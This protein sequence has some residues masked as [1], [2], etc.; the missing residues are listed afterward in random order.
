MKDKFKTKM[1]GIDTIV[2]IP[3]YYINYNLNK[4]LDSRTGRRNDVTGKEETISLKDIALHNKAEDTWLRGKLAA[5]WVQL[6]VP[7]A[8][9]KIAY[10]LEMA[11]GTMEY[12][13]NTV[14]VKIDISKWKIALLVDLDL[15]NLNQSDAPQAVKDAINN[16]KEG[17]FTIKQLFMNFQNANMASWSSTF[18]SLPESV[19]P[20][21]KAKLGD[22]LNEYIK[23]IKHAK[24]NILGYSIEVNNP[25]GI[26]SEK[27]TFVPTKLDFKI[28]K[29][30]PSIDADLDTVQ[31]LLMNDNRPF[32]A[33]ADYAPW[34]GNWIVP[35]DDKNSVYGNMAISKKCFIDE[36]LCPTLAKYVNITTKLQ[37]WDE[38]LGPKMT[39]ELGGKFQ[40]IKEGAL[41]RS[42]ANS[43]SLHVMG[44]G[45]VKSNMILEIRLNCMCVQK[46]Q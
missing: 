43:T 44:Y 46:F 5:A 10:V 41:F 22:F 17:M 21:V 30:G 33:A 1:Q 34:S 12:I 24:A 36:F 38:G 26:R 35:E 32:P 40:P 9:R 19:S 14:K 11:S 16:L 31:F 37:N 29:Y 2:S 28:N 25:G 8:H 23:Q 42:Y 45:M 27:P 18:T 3:Q 6:H 15:A 20:F 13:E 7:E 4:L 39:Q